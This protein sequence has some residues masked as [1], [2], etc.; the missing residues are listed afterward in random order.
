MNDVGQFL[1]LARFRQ[2]EH[3]VIDTDHAQIAMAG[4]IGMDEHGWRSRRGQRRSDLTP[5]MARLSHP[6]QDHAALGGKDGLDG[7]NKG[8]AQLIGHQAKGLSFGGKHAPSDG[9]GIKGGHLGCSVGAAL[10][11]LALA[12]SLACIC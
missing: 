3:D 7:G 6:G 1:D 8:L 9:D 5:H 11:V 4:L 12:A 2:G 10:T